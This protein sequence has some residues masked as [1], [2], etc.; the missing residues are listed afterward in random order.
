MA[1]SR[2]ISPRIVHQTQENIIR[3]INVGT[4]VTPLDER[5]A[6]ARHIIRFPAYTQI[7]FK[8]ILTT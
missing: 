2:P 5:F 6:R 7:I 4:G 3:V 1:I 8:F